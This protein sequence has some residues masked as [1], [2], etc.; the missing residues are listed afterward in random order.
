ML[1]PFPGKNGEGMDTA[2]PNLVTPLN[3]STM[4]RLMQSINNILKPR[5][6]NSSKPDDAILVL[7]SQ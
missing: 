7:E 3:L 2:A 6:L 5:R 1:S 4:L